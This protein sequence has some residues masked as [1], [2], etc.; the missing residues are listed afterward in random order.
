MTYY[1]ELVDKDIS[2]V[3]IE[4][5]CLTSTNYDSVNK[6]CPSFP[7]INL[8]VLHVE[9]DPQGDLAEGGHNTGMVL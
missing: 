6:F 4:N 1:R 5:I 9:L 3:H 8:F 2:R 7:S